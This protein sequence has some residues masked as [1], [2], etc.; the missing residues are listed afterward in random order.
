MS[1]RVFEKQSPRNTEISY[2]ANYETDNVLNSKYR[3][4]RMCGPDAYFKL[5]VSLAT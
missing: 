5:T 1:L 3:L 2:N 4:T